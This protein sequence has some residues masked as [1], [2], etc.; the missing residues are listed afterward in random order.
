M[1]RYFVAVACV[2]A[3]ACSSGGNEH[4]VAPVTAELHCMNGYSYV[5]VVPPPGRTVVLGAVAL[6]TERALSTVRSG[7]A[8]ALRLWTKDG[9]MVSTDSAVELRV[10]DEWRGKFS[11]SWGRP[12]DGPVE[13]V[14]VPACAASRGA[15]G[16]LGFTGGYYVADPACVS[17]IVTVGGVEQRVE[18]GIG[19]PCAG[20]DP[21]LNPSGS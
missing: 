9:L 8:P 7:L 17:M 2:L 5:G 15:G 19:A 16:W 10:A 12:E 18:I 3:A 21:P 4:A 20:Q 13:Q 14:R 11:F 6:P 1:L